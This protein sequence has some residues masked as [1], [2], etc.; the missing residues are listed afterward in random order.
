MDTDFTE[1]IRFAKEFYK[2]NLDDI[3]EMITTILVYL[4]NLRINRPYVKVSDYVDSFC[5][6]GLQITFHERKCIRAKYKYHD[7]RG[8]NVEAFNEINTHRKFM[9]YDSTYMETVLE[10]I[11]CLCFVRRNLLDKEMNVPTYK[12]LE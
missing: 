12:D 11:T 10:I 5:N 7:Y 6:Y 4:D 9:G 8:D 3:H 1:L 2:C